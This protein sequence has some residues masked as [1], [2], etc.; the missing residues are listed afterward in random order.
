MKEDPCCV[1]ENRLLKI[2]YELMDK[3]PM[4]EKYYNNTTYLVI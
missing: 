4:V 1:G 3:D 2:P